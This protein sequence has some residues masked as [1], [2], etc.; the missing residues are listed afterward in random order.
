MFNGKK[1]SKDLAMETIN[2]LNTKKSEA[3]IMICRNNDYEERKNL[4]RLID[5]IERGKDD[6]RRN[7]CSG[8]HSM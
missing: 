4:E 2:L 7:T 3:D 1:E 6:I 8:N 5:S